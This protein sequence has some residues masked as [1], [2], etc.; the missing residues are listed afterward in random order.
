ME[1]LQKFL[2]CGMGG[3]Y[4]EKTCLTAGG[5]YQ[6]INIIYIALNVQNKHLT[7]QKITTLILM[8]TLHIAQT[9]AQRWTDVTAIALWHKQ[10]QMM[11][12]GGMETIVVVMEERKMC[13]EQIP[14]P[15]IKA[16]RKALRDVVDWLER[17]E[18]QMK[19]YKLTTGKDYMAFL[20]MFRDAPDNLMEMGGF[21]DEYKMPDECKDKVKKVIEKRK[22]KNR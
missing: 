12:I 20:R 8:W 16:Y 7:D 2:G 13:N 10:E 18:Q 17:H 4:L 14:L 19:V 22:E 15:Y 5:K 9:A 21:A 6:K 1:M 3:G 11:D